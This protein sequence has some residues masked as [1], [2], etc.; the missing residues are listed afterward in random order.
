MNQKGF[1]PI[2]VLLVVAVI[3]IGGGIWHYK[4][5]PQLSQ[6]QQN[7]SVSPVA[8]ATSTGASP[9]TN[10]S[11]SRHSASNQIGAFPQESSI[12][13]SPGTI[14]TATDKFNWRLYTNAV[15]GFS[16]EYP[17]SYTLEEEGLPDTTSSFSQGELLQITNPGAP[18]GSGAEFGISLADQP[19]ANKGPVYA[20]IDSLLAYDQSEAAE[21][22]AQAE[23]TYKQVR[24][25]GTDAIQS[26]S[27]NSAGDSLAPAAADG[28]D[29]LGNNT[30]VYGLSWSPPTYGFF[31]EI[32]STFKFLRQ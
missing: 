17:A 8:I 26:F 2:I 12:A 15:W 10:T 32:A 24:V 3:L 23:E 7:Q 11:T 27:Y 20:S 16:I 5:R 31:S 18:V 28:Y 19:L 9:P 22:D 29:F 21:N 25:N 14:T 6:S 1:R 4:T 13:S 30:V